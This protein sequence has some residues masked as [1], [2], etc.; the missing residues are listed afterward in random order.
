MRAPTSAD[1]A[2]PWVRG[3]ARKKTKQ[4][5]A[6]AAP[7]AST[8]ASRRP[9][10]PAVRSSTDARTAPES[11]TAEPTSARAGGRSPCFPSASPSGT[12]ALQAVIGETM[13]IVPRASAA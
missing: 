2:E 1:N 8:T 7:T 12:I 4:P 10:S 5:M 9:A 3:L 11:A 6:S 13:L